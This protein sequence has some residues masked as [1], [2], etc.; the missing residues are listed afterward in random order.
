MPQSF[1]HVLNL[2]DM[3][4]PSAG[5]SPNQGPQP[6]I[7][8]AME[9]ARLSWR[10]DPSAEY[11]S[12]Y[13]GTATTRREDKVGNAIW[14][15]QR[16]YNRGVHKGER[17]DMSDYLWPDEFNLDSAL[18]AQ[19]MGER[20]VSPAF[21]VEPVMLTNDGRPGP[22]DEA[23]MLGQPN[24]GVPV[25]PDPQRASQLRRMLPTWR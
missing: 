14:R 22:R 5:S 1:N 8:D 23:G 2:Q 25:A 16:A 11:P 7:R 17:V 20:F 6:L 4:Q 24:T 10:R 9:A 19:S 18:V 3:A 15:N 21:A 13:L 12:G